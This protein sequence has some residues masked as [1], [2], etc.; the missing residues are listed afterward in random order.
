MYQL[1]YQYVD[2][3][4]SAPL[5]YSYTIYYHPDVYTYIDFDTSK[6]LT[7]YLPGTDTSFTISNDDIISASNSSGASVDIFLSEE[8]QIEYGKDNSDLDLDYDN[9]YTVTEAIKD[10]T[11]IVSVLNVSITAI[12]SLVST[13]FTAL[14]TEIRL[15][16]TFSLSMGIL[17]IF[18]KIIRG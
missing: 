7:S 16:L 4:L 18:V 2:G 8:N 3:S 14:P 10:S 12:L 6:D 11:K 15:L 9:A 1:G 5:K 13:L 17:I